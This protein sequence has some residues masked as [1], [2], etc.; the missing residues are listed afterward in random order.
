MIKISPLSLA[1]LAVVG[2]ST[3]C[4]AF[5]PASFVNNGIINTN[6]LTAAST[7]ASSTKMNMLDPTQLV[8]DAT[9]LLSTFDFGGSSNLLSFADQGQNLAGIFFQASL[10]PYLLFLYFLSFKGNRTPE[11]GNF[12]WQFLLLFV[13]ATIPSGIISKTTYDTTLANVDWLHGGAEALLTTTNVLIVLGFRNAMTIPKEEQAPLLKTKTIALGTAAAFAAAC[14]LG[15]TLG[16]EAHSAFLLG[17]GNLP[18]SVVESLPWV[19]ECEIHLCI[20]HL[21]NKV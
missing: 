18:E 21:V 20:W 4:S 13:F 8:N 14:A 5:T 1:A 17:L 16:F 2:L 10:L 12:G 6:K 11:L 7:M 3:Q 19:S 9:N 15:P